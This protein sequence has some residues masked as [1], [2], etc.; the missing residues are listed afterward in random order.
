MNNKKFRLRNNGLTFLKE[1]KTISKIYWKKKF[2]LTGYRFYD[3]LYQFYF[4][5]SLL[6]CCMVRFIGD[7]LLDGVG[8]YYVSTFAEFQMLKYIIPK[9]E[10]GN[11]SGHT[12]FDSLVEKYSSLEFYDC[13]HHFL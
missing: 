8:Y 1:I 2:C 4:L 10:R 3:S 13:K 6:R 12:T 7:K 5:E 11:Y 9:H